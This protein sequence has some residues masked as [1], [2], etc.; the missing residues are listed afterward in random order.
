[1]DSRISTPESH[2]GPEAVPS[3]AAIGGHPIHPM[4]IPIPIG[5]LTIA[6]LSDLVYWGTGNPFWAQA[7]MWLIGVGVVSGVV[8]AIAGAV[9]FIGIPRVRRYRSAWIH[10]I[11]NWIALALALINVLLRIG[12]PAAAAFPVGLILSAI[13]FVLLGVTG[14]LGGELSYRHRIGVM[15]QADAAAGRD[16][17]SPV[18]GEANQH[19]GT[20]MGSR[21]SMNV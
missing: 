8:A 18:H 1:M 5:A 21:G 19:G 2:G 14:W 12:D 10:A 13:T 11:G 17:Q 20:P 4:L 6:L 15:R 7:S 16:A 3:K 9:D